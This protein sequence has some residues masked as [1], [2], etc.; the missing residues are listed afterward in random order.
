MM[1]MIK[2]RVVIYESDNY[3]QEKVMVCKELFSAQ[4]L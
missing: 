3:M 2:Q 1:M 4:K